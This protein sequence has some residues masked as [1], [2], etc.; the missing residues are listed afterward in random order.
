MIPGR[1]K[2]GNIPANLVGQR[3]IKRK[4]SVNQRET[5]DGMKAMILAAGLG[6]RL[7]PITDNLPKAL[8]EVNG[9]PMLDHVLE[10]LVAAGFTEIIVNAHHFSG[11]VIA[12]LE[13]RS[14]PG[15]R[16]GISDESDLL[17]DTGG[18]ILKARWFLDGEEPFLVH[19]ADVIS[20]IDLKDMMRCHLDKKPLATLAVSHRKS[21]RYF[22]MDEELRLRGWE[23][24]ETGE[25]LPAKGTPSGLNKLAFSGIHVID[26]TIFKHLNQTGKFSIISAYLQLCDTNSVLGYLHDAT[27]W[28]DLGKPEQL[29]LA[30]KYLNNNTL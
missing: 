25:K 16:I 17:L 19:N 8:V 22:L 15:V 14:F 10:R 21:S 4:T 3:R 7:A 26:P 1:K 20:G 6:T 28:F 18:A 5:S 24:T 23:N 2:K 29:I 13:K 9:K 11:M 30:E 12:H 27:I